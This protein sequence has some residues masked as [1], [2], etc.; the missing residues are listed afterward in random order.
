MYNRSLHNIHML[1]VLRCVLEPYTDRRKL[2]MTS[3]S[4]KTQQACGMRLPVGFDWSCSVVTIPFFLSC[5]M[6]VCMLSV[7]MM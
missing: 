4:G 3:I 7:C 2:F 5:D 6:Y 1:N